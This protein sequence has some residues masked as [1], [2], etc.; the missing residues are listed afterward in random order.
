MFLFICFILKLFIFIT[1]H[2]IWFKIFNFFLKRNI[3]IILINIYFFYILNLLNLLL[4]FIIN[5]W[6]YQAF[7]IKLS[8]SFNSLIIIFI[9]LFFKR[10]GSCHFLI[11][12]NK[13]FLFYIRAI[14]TCQFF[15]IYH[16]LETTGYIRH[17]IFWI[18][19]I[20]WTS[21]NF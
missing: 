18:I 20:I 14:F 5:R 19:I 16:W 8:W 9:I 12:I 4:Y 13:L 6:I 11:N 17:N 21:L 7:I 15:I 10:K 2:W 3:I 1:W